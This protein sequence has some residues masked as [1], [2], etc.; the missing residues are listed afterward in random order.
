MKKLL[1]ILAIPIV[2]IVVA[3]AAL[4][5]FVNPNQ[6][7]P[8]ITEQVQAQTGLELEI[9][10]DIS[11]QFFPSLGFELGQTNLKNP[12]GFKNPNLF[13][14]SQVG[15]SVGVMPLLDKTLEIGS[16][17]LDGAQVHLETLKRRNV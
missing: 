16:V 13:S 4:V 11:W 17:T 14:V 10:G 9:S 1:L 8:M 3:I 6:F 5:M 15:V 2:L 12:Q 7:K